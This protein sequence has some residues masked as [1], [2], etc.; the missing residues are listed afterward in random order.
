MA[1]PESSPLVDVAG[2]LDAE[3]ATY[4]RLGELFLRAPLDSVKH[5]ERAKVTLDELAQS[6]QRLQE[7]AQRLIGALTGVRQRQEELAKRVV[8]HAPAL[9]ARNVRL[10]ELLALL[11]GVAEGVAAMNQDLQ[12]RDP[13]QV[14]DDVLALST[15]AEQLASEARGSDFPELADQAH[16]LQQRLRAIGK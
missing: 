12:A 11:H 1:K 9:Q 2:E 10:N 6:E 8:E 5:L 3:L 14:G 16:S 7:T 15:R 13:G 4:N